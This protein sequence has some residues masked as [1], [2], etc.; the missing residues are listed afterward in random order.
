M[1]FGHRSEQNTVINESM[2]VSHPFHSATRLPC[3][4]HDAPVT[5][6]HPS[7]VPQND[8]LPRFWDVTSDPRSPFLGLN[9]LFAVGMPSAEL[10]N[11]TFPTYSRQSVTAHHP[12]ARQHAPSHPFFY[13]FSKSDCMI[14]TLKFFGFFFHCSCCKLPTVKGKKEPQHLQTLQLFPQQVG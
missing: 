14:L 9:I 5:S 8:S 1:L 6:A 13:R 12:E 10:T 2:L 4:W 7:S 3:C 11:T